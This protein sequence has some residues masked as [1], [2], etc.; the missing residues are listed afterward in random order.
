MEEAECEMPVYKCHKEVW[1]LKIAD[2]AICEGG[3]LVRPEESGYAAFMV[4]NEYM[5]KHKPKIGGYYVV[6]GDGYKSF[7]PAIA[8]EEG[9]SRK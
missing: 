9:Y 3:A 4:S 2:I 6:Y 5:H 7:S 8:F 1:A